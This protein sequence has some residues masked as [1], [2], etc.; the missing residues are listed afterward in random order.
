V[1]H[2][3]G[4]ARGRRPERPGRTPGHARLRRPPSGL[5]LAAAA[6]LLA[7][8]CGGRERA[9]RLRIHPMLAAQRARTTSLLQAVAAVDDSVA[10]AAGH[11]DIW[12]RTLDGGEHWTVGTVPGA[13]GLELRD[14]WASGPDTAFLLTAGAGDRS[15]IYATTDAGASWALRFTNADSSAFFDCIDFWDARSGLAFS[16][17]VAGRFRVLRTEDGGR[18]WS[19]ID[20]LLPTAREGEGGFAASGGCLV[21][22]AGGRGWIGTG[23]ADSARILRTG[24]RGAS[25]SWAPVPIRGGREAGVMA[26]AFRDSLHGLAVGGELG[27]SD[28]RVRVAVSDDGGR[29]WRAG[30]SPTLPGP[31]YGAAW[32][33]G[34]PSPTAVVVG[35]GGADYTIDGG[36]SWTPLDTAS[37]WSVGFA[38]PRAGWMVGPGGRISRVSLVALGEGR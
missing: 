10:W 25:W 9:E 11:D 18:S 30:G 33:P 21:V 27:A 37:Y 8:S 20:T 2:R 24:D 31:L 26:V 35:P 12:L 5:L 14:V 28:G 19:R 36:E 34:A 15:R 3:R 6:A 16:D 4:G 38:S 17:A 7:V 32:V 13:A 22:G 23:A 29:S 1:T